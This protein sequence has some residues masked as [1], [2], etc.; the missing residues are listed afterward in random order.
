MCSKYEKL[1]KVTEDITGYLHNFYAALTGV[2][3]PA[4]TLVV[5]YVSRWPYAFFVCFLCFV[6][7]S[8]QLQAG[9]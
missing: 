7:L 3:I 4:E 1:R 6:E 2:I 5:Y 8:L 9:D